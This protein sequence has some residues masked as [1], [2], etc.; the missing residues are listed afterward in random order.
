V[1]LPRQDDLQ[2]HNGVLTTNTK[3]ST[4]RIR[5]NPQ[6]VGCLGKL[7]NIDESIRHHFLLS[8]PIVECFHGISSDCKNSIISWCLVSI[9]PASNKIR[10][11]NGYEDTVRNAQSQQTNTLEA[12]SIV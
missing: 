8:A 10:N 5:G 3:T 7:K 11:T 2:G 12:V 4:H 9:H 1:S 6:E